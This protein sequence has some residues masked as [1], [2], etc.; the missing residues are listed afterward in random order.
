MSTL[1]ID[2]KNLRMTVENQ[3]L[4]FYE[5]G[6][7]TATMPLNVLERICIKGNLELDAHTLG[8]LGENSIGILVLSGRQQR[9]TIMLPN[10]KLDGRRRSIQ[11]AQAAHYPTALNIAK[12][13][14]TEKLNRQLQF[15]QYTDANYPD[16][17]A[18]RYHHCQQ[19][20]QILRQ[21][22]DIR[23][24]DT[25]RGLEGAAAARYFNAWQSFLPKSLKFSGRNR[26]PPKDPLNSILSLG[27]TL[28][29]FE[30]VKHIHLCGLDPYIGFY[31]SPVHGRESLA[32]DLLEPIRPQYDQWAISLFQKHTLSPQDFSHTTAQGCMLRKKGRL[33]YYSAYE[34][35]AKTWRP[36]I[37]QSCRKLLHTI[38]TNAGQPE[39]D[40]AELDIL[41]QTTTETEATA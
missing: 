4:V 39:L 28:L 20:I 9:P 22:P 32:C 27:Y 30:I 37:H 7:R 36:Y 2:R 21:I 8:K 3:T 41:T 35:N 1:Y 40:T 18:H 10:W 6:K 25:L 5:S 23:N 12:N 19:I 15:L 16:S 14:V 24:M 33:T 13:L 34:Q 26:R 29:H 38:T 31:H 11:Y 17:A